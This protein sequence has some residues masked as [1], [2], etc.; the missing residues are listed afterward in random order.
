MKVK[1]GDLKIGKFVED[2][3]ALH[4]QKQVERERKPIKFFEKER[5]VVSTD[6][7]QCKY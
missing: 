3:A 5:L 2:V 1:R 7:V 4:W 6:K